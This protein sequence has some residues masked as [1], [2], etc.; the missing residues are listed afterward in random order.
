[1]ELEDELVGSDGGRTTT[2]VSGN[3][4]YGMLPSAAAPNIVRVH[5]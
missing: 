2:G 1:M 5:D 3:P 4:A